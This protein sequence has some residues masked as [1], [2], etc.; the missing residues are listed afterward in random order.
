MHGQPVLLV[1]VDTAFATNFVIDLAWLLAALRLAGLP[2]RWWRLVL[3]AAAGAGLAVWAYFPSGR[4]LAGG[5]GAALGTALILALAALPCPL[6][7]LAQAAFW[8]VLT[9]G[10]AAGLTM[11]AAAR[12]QMVGRNFAA[13]AVLIFAG[14]MLAL[15]GGRQVL[16]AWKERVR[17]AR[18]LCRVRISLAGETA[19]LPALVDTGNALADPFT[20][21][22]VVVVEAQA[23][24]RLLPPGLAEAVGRGWQ[25]LDSLPRDWAARCRL[26]PFQ[27][28][29]RPD[30]MLL[31]LAPDALAVWSPDAPGA[32][33]EPV[34]GLVGLAGV[35]LHKEGAYQAL[36]PPAL[37]EGAGRSVEQ[38]GETG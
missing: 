23:L 19:E 8:F 22:P 10:T 36:L 34:R 14:W 25:G 3:S 28:V 24:G 6:K 30:G 1:Y 11:L 21:T 37:V 17:L 16:S 29:G 20:R 13:P 27:A 26:V 5:P 32:A 31:A 35:R 33:W 18:G 12:G 7:R 38:R 15:V 4:W 2:A 9:G